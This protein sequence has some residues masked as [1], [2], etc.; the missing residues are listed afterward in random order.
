[1][2]YAHSIGGDGRCE[3]GIA[4]FLNT[5]GARALMKNNNTPH[6]YLYYRTPFAITSSSRVHRSDNSNEFSFI[7]HKN[8]T[9]HRLYTH[10]LPFCSVYTCTFD[11][12]VIHT[13][14][15]RQAF[16]YGRPGKNRNNGISEEIRSTIKN[17]TSTSF[18]T[19]AFPTKKKTLSGPRAEHRGNKPITV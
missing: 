16:Y 6:V 15:V 9:S 4:A 11:V 5:G 8:T 10:T 12:L 18:R 7:R 13:T 14:T 2:V 17:K 3:K 19:A 1:M